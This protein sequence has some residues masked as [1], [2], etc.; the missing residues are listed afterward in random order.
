MLSL[1]RIAARPSSLKIQFQLRSLVIGISIVAMALAPVRAE[2]ARCAAI[3]E[4]VQQV[5]RAKGEVSF[6]YQL[7]EEGAILRQLENSQPPWIRRAL[8]AHAFSHVVEIMLDRTQVSVTTFKLIGERCPML[9]QLS[10]RGTGTNNGMLQSLAKCQKLRYLELSETSVSD[11]GLAFF[12]GHPELET[13]CIENTQVSGSC[14]AKLSQLKRLQSLSACNS[15]INDRAIGQLADSESLQMLF[16]AGRLGC[17]HGEQLLMNTAKTTI[18]H[19]QN[20][21]TRLG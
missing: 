5:V 8:G 11:P 3:E 4:L 14:F 1:S 16:L 6:N 18:A 10:L 7:I 17:Y 19:D 9:L 20:V 2:I 12:A 21:I 13:L 15:P